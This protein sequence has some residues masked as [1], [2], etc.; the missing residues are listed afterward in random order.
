MERWHRFISGGKR[1]GT[2]Q[3]GFTLIEMLVLVNIAGILAGTVTLTMVGLT[4]PARVQL[5][6]QGQ[7]TEQPAMAPTGQRQLRPRGA[8]VQ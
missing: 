1:G 6:N 5:C 4:S 7:K 2:G 8:N 3:R